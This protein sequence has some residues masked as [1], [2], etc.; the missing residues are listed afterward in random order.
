MVIGLEL[1]VF[2]AALGA[3]AYGAMIGV[4]GGLIMVPLLA[5]VLGVDIHLAIAASLLGVI[6]VSTVAS[7]TYLAHGLV[8]RRL[9]LILLVA[10]ALGGMAGG[11]VAGLLDG[12]ALAGL[13]GLLMLFVAAQ[14][15]RGQR[16]PP[17]EP[18]DSPGRLEFDAAYLEPTSGERIAYRAR[19]VGLGA[20][21][22]L[23]AG[24]LSGLLGVGGGVINVPTLNVLMGVPIRVATTTST[25]MLGATAAAS[26]VI[27]Y[28]RGQVDPLL[29]AP[30]VI[31][32]LIGALVGARLATRVSRR[33]LQLG[34]AGV[35]L[36]FA[37]QMLWRAWV[38]A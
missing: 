15:V 3:G 17:S 21:V 6:A 31:G 2:L 14:M 25:Y 13:F 30:V 34:F 19:R 26:A 4:G 8:D 18:V 5:A 27:Y 37:V 1:L 12:R 28:G 7:T 23:A 11:Y 29:A 16:V 35:A 22:S 10:T 36:V 24:A 9:G 32:V 33:A 20:T 38:G